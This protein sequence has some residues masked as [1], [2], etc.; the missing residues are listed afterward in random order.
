M[1]LVFLG[2]YTT[3]LA[4]DFW[5]DARRR[6]HLPALETSDMRERIEKYFLECDV[7]YF[8]N[9][10]WG[11]TA[12]TQRQN[13]FWPAWRWKVKMDLRRWVDTVNMRQG[14]APS[15]SMVARRWNTLGHH[16][17]FSL[18]NVDDPRTSGAARVRLHKWRHAAGVRWK[19]IRIQERITLEEKRSKVEPI[20]NSAEL[21][22][23]QI[24]WLAFGVRK[25][26]LIS[27]PFVINL[28]KMGLIFGTNMV[29]ELVPQNRFMNRGR[30]RV[31][32]V[33]S[34]S[35]AN[36]YLE[37]DFENQHGRN[38]S[39]GLPRKCERQRYKEA[40]VRRRSGSVR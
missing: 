7:D 31:A 14:L 33:A 22:K 17:V 3:D 4:V 12:S 13:P 35:C 27:E 15:S 23:Y 8:V 2:N 37:T 5:R 30:G 18:Q 32:M 20:L 6:K 24:S 39:R 1:A 19:A 10:G 38:I 36:R 25:T 9:L 21:R 11:E 26:V 28:F 40:Q 34:S 16:P 29:T